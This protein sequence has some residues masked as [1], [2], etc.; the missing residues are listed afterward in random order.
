MGQRVGPVS[1]RP[2]TAKE[3][4]KKGLERADYRKHRSQNTDTSRTKL[5]FRLGQKCKR[6][7]GGRRE[8]F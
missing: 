7:S 5:M 6:E 2:K 4:A 1:K 8:Y 3:R